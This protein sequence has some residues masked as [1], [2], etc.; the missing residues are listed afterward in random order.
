MSG[1]V[2]DLGPPTP[3]RVAQPLRVPQVLP[4]L[5]WPD[6]IFFLRSR[7]GHPYPC[8]G[9]RTAL[10]SDAVLHVDP[11][12]IRPRPFRFL[13]RLPDGPNAPQR[14]AGP[15]KRHGRPA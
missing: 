3:A 14:V 9:L 4:N 11:G 5:T 2:L 12:A 7:H 13:L 8:D 6:T 15:L 1:E 10:L